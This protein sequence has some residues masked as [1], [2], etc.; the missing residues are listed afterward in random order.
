MIH[1][2]TSSSERPFATKKYLDIHA[3]KMAYIDEGEGQTILFQH[4]NPTSSYLWRNVMPHLKGPNQTEVTVEGGHYI[5]ETAPDE[6]G[7]AIAD[8]VRRLRS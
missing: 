6:V 7:A 3:H 1:N 2:A 8:F 4:G 5:Q